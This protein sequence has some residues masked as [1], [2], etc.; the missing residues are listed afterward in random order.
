[1]TSTPGSGRS[2]SSSAPLLFSP[3]LSLETIQISAPQDGAYKQLMSHV[4]TVLQERLPDM[5]VTGTWCLERGISKSKSRQYYSILKD[6]MDSD[7]AGKRL[8]MHLG[9][10]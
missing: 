10:A 4:N 1:M 3:T 8:L 2:S 5:V 6:G 7:N 9:E